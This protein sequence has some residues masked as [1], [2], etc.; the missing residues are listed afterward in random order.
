MVEDALT[1]EPAAV[2]R[3][4]L[5]RVAFFFFGGETF[6][7]RSAIAV[8]GVSRRK[9]ARIDYPNRSQGPVPELTRNASI[10]LNDRV[11]LRWSAITIA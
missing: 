9:L 10:Q 1:S 4:D 6:I 2:A 11:S 5:S 8:L 7:N 3:F